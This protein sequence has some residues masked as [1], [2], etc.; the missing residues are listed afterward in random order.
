MEA[1][2]QVAAY[3]SKLDQQPIRDHYLFWEILIYI[4]C[5]HKI[6]LDLMG[7]TRF[8]LKQILPVIVLVFK[9]VSREFLNSYANF[10]CMCMI[11]MVVN[12]FNGGSQS[13]CCLHQYVRPAA[14]QTD[15]SSFT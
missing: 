1:A 11:F 6:Y 8:S 4:R 5:N 12:I 2:N 10:E 7:L 14:N 15:L 13:Y 3:I 9:K